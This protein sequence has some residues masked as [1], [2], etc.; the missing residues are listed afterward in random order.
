LS[1]I[2]LLKV[3]EEK[4]FVIV[5][6]DEIFSTMDAQYTVLFA[7]VFVGRLRAM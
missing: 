3:A 7:R 2:Y 4:D 1:W 6:A 5:E